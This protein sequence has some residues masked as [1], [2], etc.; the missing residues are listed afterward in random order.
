MD[1]MAFAR[2]ISTTQIVDQDQEKVRTVQKWRRGRR[3]APRMILPECRAQNGRH[4]HQTETRRQTLMGHSDAALISSTRMGIESMKGK[5]VAGSTTSEYRDFTP[6]SL[7]TSTA[8]NFS[9]E[10]L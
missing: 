9:L 5:I 6:P 4:H 7:P 2:E 1:H 8:S 10:S 3:R